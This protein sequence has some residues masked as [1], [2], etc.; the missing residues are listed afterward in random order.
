MPGVIFE[1]K[2]GPAALQ[3]YYSSSPS[4]KGKTKSPATFQN[5]NRSLKEVMDK[6][7]TRSNAR[8]TEGEQS[9]SLK[10]APKT[11]KIQ[12]D[13]LT[14]KKKGNYCRSHLKK[15]ASSTMQFRKKNLSLLGVMGKPKPD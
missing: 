6:A 9:P 13:S 11:I 5:D 2:T 1:T 15:A 7:K 8:K 3:N 14:R 4:A 10:Y 12:N